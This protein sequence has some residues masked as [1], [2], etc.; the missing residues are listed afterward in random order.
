[1]SQ[2][3]VDE[4]DAPPTTIK[5]YVLLRIEDGSARS[6]A[7]TAAEPRRR[8]EQRNEVR[9]GD[10]ETSTRKKKIDPGR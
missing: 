8:R 7:S 5:S 2:E 10:I 1:M 4:R 6:A 9:E 3:T